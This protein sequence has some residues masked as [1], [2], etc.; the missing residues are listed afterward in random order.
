[1]LQF[2]HFARNYN[3]TPLVLISAN[4][5]TTVSGNLAAVRNGITTWIEVKHNVLFYVTTDNEIIIC[6][7]AVVAIFAFVREN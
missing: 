2:V 7:I 4:H 3:V 5:S 6:D 1:M